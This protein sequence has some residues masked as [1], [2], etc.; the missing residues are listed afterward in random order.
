MNENNKRIDVKISF[1]C[2]NSC[3]FCVQ[4]DKR[5][6]FPDKN[7]QEIM[8]IL[9][10]ERI[11]CN[12][13]VFTGG[14]PTIQANLIDYVKYAKDL[15]YKIIQIQ[16]NG[17]LFFYKDYCLRLIKAGAN[18]FNPAI[19]GSSAKIHD[20]L[21]RSPGSFK[22]TME[23]IKNLYNLK[24]KMLF[25]TVINKVNY[26][27]LPN[28]VRMLVNFKPSVLQLAFMHISPLVQ[29]DPSLVKEIVPRY[30][31]IEKYVKESLQVGIK[32]KIN[33]NTEAIPYCFMKDYE[34][35]VIEDR[36]PN[37]NIYDADSTIKN[38]NAARKINEKAKGPNCHKCKYNKICEGPWRDY[39]DIFGWDEFKPV[40]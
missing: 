6:R 3:R 18:V 2:N 23:G 12:S 38:F 31:Q 30:F 24:Q 29:K 32:A 35:Y 7:S 9:R 27:D 26:Q 22:Q 36:I 20:Y 17:R 28:I 40:K 34:K 16:T 33:I 19:H 8:S 1:Q 5:D 11:N 37:T 14:E 25:N 13:V 21:T 15:D 4:G 10:E 39:P